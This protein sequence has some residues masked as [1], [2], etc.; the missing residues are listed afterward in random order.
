MEDTRQHTRRPKYEFMVT[1]V[2]A[3][4]QINSA[5]FVNELKR[6]VQQ[7][8]RESNRVEIDRVVSTGEVN[9]Y[10]ETHIVYI[11]LDEC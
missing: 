5:A 6:M 2:P 3:Q 4:G 9:R 8:N 1:L 11:H 10:S 7:H